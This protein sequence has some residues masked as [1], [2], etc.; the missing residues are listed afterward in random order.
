MTELEELNIAIEKRL[1]EDGVLKEILVANITSVVGTTSKGF[2]FEPVD[3][4]TSLFPLPTVSKGPNEIVARAFWWGFHLQ[5]PEQALEEI[6]TAIANGTPFVGLLG[7]VTGPAAPY[8]TLIVAFI[9]AEYAWMKGVNRGK[10]VYLS[11][12]WAAP[13][14]FVPTPIR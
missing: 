5:I 10:G 4:E 3:L 9:N 12:T 7:S 1:K 8:I 13:G 6:G 2:L 14:I 11:M